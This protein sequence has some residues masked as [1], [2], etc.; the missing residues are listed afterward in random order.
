MSHRG[1]SKQKYKEKRKRGQR[2]DGLEFVSPLSVEDCQAHLK[3]GR[4]PSRNFELWVETDEHEF[5]IG[6]RDPSMNPLSRYSF[7]APVW[8]EG[9]LE[10][11]DAGTV[12]QGALYR[13]STRYL[14]IG[15]L[16]IC[17]LIF[18][19]ATYA[20][21]APMLQIFAVILAFGGLIIDKENNRIRDQMGRMLREYVIE[22][23]DVRRT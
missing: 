18:L 17:L 8:F 20:N 10:P 7:L 16:A 2:V 15:W 21:T 3:A 19:G 22:R 5:S 6:F 9:H 1:K 13:D 11:I 14:V 4:S 12:V 23:L